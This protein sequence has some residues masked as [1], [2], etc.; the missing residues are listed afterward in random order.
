MNQRASRGHALAFLREGPSENWRSAAVGW[1]ASADGRGCD[2]DSEPL[3]AAARA[4]RGRRFDH[5]DARGCCNLSGFARGIRARGAA[6]SGRGRQWPQILETVLG[7]GSIATFGRVCPVLG[8]LRPPARGCG[9]RA[10]NPRPRGSKESRGLRSVPLRPHRPRAGRGLPRVRRA[11][12]L[13]TAR[14]ANPSLTPDGG[15]T[16]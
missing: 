13:S 3:V 7:F 15:L 10:E 5:D 16:L 6:S 14:T 2:V 12:A 9:T 4:F 8:A 1:G 11:P